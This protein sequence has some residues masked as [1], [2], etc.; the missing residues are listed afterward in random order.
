VHQQHV[1]YNKDK[2]CREAACVEFSNTI[3]SPP[4]QDC[5][6]NQVCALIRRKRFGGFKGLCGLSKRLGKLKSIYSPKVSFEEHL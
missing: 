2:G 5:F 4:I 3:F 1:K 6:K